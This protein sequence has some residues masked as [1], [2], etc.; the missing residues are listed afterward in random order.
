MNADELLELLAWVPAVIVA[1]FALMPL[2]ILFNQRLPA[3]PDMDPLDLAQ[4][5][6]ATA[7]HLMDRTR[8]LIDLG[9]AD[10][11]TLELPE[12]APMVIGY[13]ILVA[14][15]EAGDMAMAVTLVGAGGP[16]GIKTSYVEFTTELADWTMFDTYNSNQLGAFPASPT[17]VK[18]QAW[19]VTDTAEL[20]RLHRHVMAAHA[21]AGK[22]ELYPDDPDAAADWLSWHAFERLYERL[23]ERGWLRR[24]RDRRTFVPTVKGAYLMTWGLMPPVTWVRKWLTA[25]HAARLV[26]DMRA[27]EGE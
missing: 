1:A 26:A 13:L 3:R 23:E 25:R 2:M 8:E 22:R 17:T 10:P 16:L 6:K 20:Y 27:S 5:P 9:F 14:N 19:A 21:A 24:T 4:L 12:P 7:R 15:R 11:V 18:T